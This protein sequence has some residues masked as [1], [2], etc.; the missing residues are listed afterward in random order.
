MAK[1]NVLNIIIFNPPLE[2]KPLRICIFIF[3]YACDFAFNALFYLNDNI[4][5]IYHYTGTDRLFFSLI[6][7]LT[8]SLASTIVS[9]LLL[10]FFQSLTQSS[11]K[12]GKLFK[13]Q[14]SLLKANKEYKVSKD[15]KA[16]IN[17]EIKKLLKWLKI[18]IINFYYF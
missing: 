13:D 1:D 9:S 7:N 17:N 3:S 15:T 16:N 5:D 12:I 2:L 8:I 11:N 10:I 14:D 4:S 18:K 6:N